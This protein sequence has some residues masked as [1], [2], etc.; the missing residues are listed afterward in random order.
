MTEYVK[1]VVDAFAGAISTGIPALSGKVLSEWPNRNDQL[2]IPCAAVLMV[3]PGFTGCAPY[4]IESGVVDAV[5]NTATNRYVVGQYDSRIQVD[6]WA[7]NK[8]ERAAIC[9]ALFNLIHGIRATGY[10]IQLSSYFDRW[11]CFSMESGPKF[12][13]D[14]QAATRQEWRAM[15]MFEVGCNAVREGVDYMITEEPELLFS[16]PINIPNE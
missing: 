4:L 14:E 9:Q 10:N 6:V 16:L 2:T 7:K 3:E 13:Q 1:A 11:A 12:S 8:P 5:T 15:F